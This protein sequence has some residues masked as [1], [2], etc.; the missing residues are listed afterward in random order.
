MK[1]IMSFINKNNGN[2][3][4]LEECLKML[5]SLTSIADRSD[6]VFLI[7]QLL[8]FEF[9]EIAYVILINSNTN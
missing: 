2:E 1:P 4:V 8:Y 9:I 6:A 7:D 3:K 5:A